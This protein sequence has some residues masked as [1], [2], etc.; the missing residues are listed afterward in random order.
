MRVDESNESVFYPGSTERKRSA[1]G[2]GP[3]IPDSEPQPWEEMYELR[4][5]GGK[6]MRFYPISALAAALNRSVATVRHW[7]E[8][9]ILPPASLRTDALGPQGRRRVYTH[10]QIAGLQRIA[11]Q[12]GLFKSNRVYVRRTKFTSLAFELFKALEVGE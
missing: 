10:E 8:N 3:T 6:Q 2:D 4:L 1:G 9:G 11:E 7:D 5:Y 12:E